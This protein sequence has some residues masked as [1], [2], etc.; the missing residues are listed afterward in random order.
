LNRTNPVVGIDDPQ[1]F[2]RLGLGHTVL[3]PTAGGVVVAPQTLDIRVGEIV[4]DRRPIRQRLRLEPAGQVLVLT[5]QSRLEIKET[6]QIPDALAHPVE[7]LQGQL[8]AGPDRQQI[9]V[10]LVA[11]AIAGKVTRDKGIQAGQPV[12]DLGQELGPAVQRQPLVGL[13]LP[14]L[15]AHLVKDGK[16]PLVATTAVGRHVR[17]AHGGRPARPPGRH[18]R[19]P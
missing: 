2:Q 1:R 14:G 10:G 7:L 4:P 13:P 8:P 6:G 18:S 17:Q 16:G 19:L 5:A 9:E 12:L 15:A 3:I 11:D